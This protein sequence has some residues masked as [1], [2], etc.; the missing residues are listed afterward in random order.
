MLDWYSYTSPARVC[1]LV[2]PIDHCSETNYAR[3][4]NLI[5][6]SADEVRLLDIPAIP[7][8][9]YFNPQTFP[10]GNIM[11]DYVSWMPDKE[12]LFLN[13]FEPFR[14][15]FVV[16][17]VG[18]YRALMSEEEIETI[19]NDLRKLYPSSIVHNLILMDTPFDEIN[20][21]TPKHDHSTK[22]VF[23]HDGTNERITL[24]ETLMCEVSRNFLISFDS[25]ASSYSNITL[26]SPI[27]MT[28]S[29]T[30]TKTISMAKKRL[31]G[32]NSLK[33]PFSSSLAGML[34]TV[35]NKSRSQQGNRGRQAKLFGNFF[36][37]AGK[38]NDALEHFTDATAKLR[39]AE[40]YL[41]LASAL[42]GVGISVILLNY[43]KASYRLSSDIL[44]PA[45]NI[46][47]HKFLSF[48]SSSV[49]KESLSLGRVSTESASNYNEALDRRSESPRNSTN[50]ASN[51]LNNANSLGDLNSFTIPEFIR[52]ISTRVLFYYQLITHDYENIVPDI[53]YVETLLR[54]VKFMTTLYLGG[55]ELNTSV[56]L[57][58]TKSR[59]LHKDF[60]TAKPEAT[61]GFLKR[62][63]LA[64]IGKVFTIQ[65][66]DFNLSDQCNI[67]CALATIYSDLGLQR[68]K[69]S[70]LRVLLVALCLKL[71]PIY[72]RASSLLKKQGNQSD[73][74]VL[75]ANRN[76]IFSIRNIFEHLFY[77]YQINLETE[78]TSSQAG[79][80]SQS[81]WITLQLSVIKLCLRVTETIGD[82]CYLA[83]LYILL[84]TRYCHCLPIHDQCKLKE[85]L[86]E[87]VLS[88]AKDTVGLP[89]WDPFLVRRVKLVNYKGKDELISFRD[90]EKKSE[91]I[92]LDASQNLRRDNTNDNNGV[93]VFNPFE[94]KPQPFNIKD[95]LLVENEVHHLKVKL[96]NP[97][98]FE[99][100]ITDLE[101]MTEK[102]AS[103]ITLKSSIKAL[104]SLPLGVMSPAGMNLFSK[105]NYTTS[106][107]SGIPK[108][109]LSSPLNEGRELSESTHAEVLIRIPPKSTQ[110]VIVPFRPLAIGDLNVKGFQIAILA[111]R[112]QFF[113]IIDR[114]IFV[115][116][117][118]VKRWHL[119]SPRKGMGH[120]V[121][122]LI[123]NLEQ[124]HIDSRV[125]ARTLNLIV[126]PSQP[127][128]SLSSLLIINNSALILE[129]ERM[130]FSVTL[131]NQSN[132]KINYLSFSF[133]DSTIDSLSSRLQPINTRGY[134]L[135][136]TD[137]YELEWLLL[138]CKPFQ[139][140][141][142]EEI[143][144]NCKVINPGDD[145]KIDYEVT[146]KRGMN[147]L[148]IILEYSNK[149]SNDSLKNLVK[150]VEVPVTFAVAPSLEVAGFDV[151]P[152]F[153]SS[154]E[155]FCSDSL[156]NSSYPNLRGIR[157]WILEKKDSINFS[158]YC[159]M[160]LDLR[161]SWKEPLNVNL[162]VS[163]PR[164]D[165]FTVNSE[166]PSW[167]TM[168]F[169]LPKKRVSS[170]D[171][172]WKKQIPSLRQKQYVKDYLM[173][174]EENLIMRKLH[175]LR[176]HVLD[177]VTGTWSTTS[178]SRKPR[179]GDVELRSIRL[180]TRVANMLTVSDISLQH[181]VLKE[182][183]PDIP[184]V[185][186][187]AHVPIA[188]EEF[189]TLKTIIVNN[190]L[191]EVVG[192]LRHLPM[193]LTSVLSA[194][195][196][197]GFP[198]ST[199]MNQ[200]SIGRRILLNGMFQH[201]IAES[202]K[203]GESRE[204]CISFTI[205][206]KGEY[207][208]GSILDVFNSNGLRVVTDDPLYIN[209]L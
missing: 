184:L 178:S 191:Q 134:F 205:L 4:L 128:L 85:N 127:V 101:I 29:Q 73:I 30:L 5:R 40:D 154:I 206:E 22:D 186:S 57:S 64:E 91:S 10:S 32:S 157:E 78:K 195:S 179:S 77:V 130:Q 156:A 146:G 38:V 95:K 185:S 58:I 137:V 149:V 83:K 147:D 120:T 142:K 67:Y 140:I 104:D 119:D 54:S 98:A 12:T 144:K 161:N 3:Y 121:D 44:L 201:H 177:V 37:L 31:L 94:K 153:T 175:W 124:S 72:Q 169:F 99:L 65:L 51:S 108:K 181:M 163:F 93:V 180:S 89:Y 176:L 143:L 61:I 42:E 74:L 14:K 92:N 198:M 49:S 17:G 15:I 79:N 190:S 69:A 136:A 97:Y 16:L 7:E 87:L 123:E 197:E 45:L 165:D 26:R 193:P 107:V 46:H 103:V 194:S 66:A 132:T 164:S 170:N 53:V 183:E 100:D 21:L 102:P 86:K 47:K 109:S 188:V 166:I 182:N 71:E 116:P 202:I 110:Q 23:Y 167:R 158:E 162:N 118:R 125:S 145:I 34:S 80:R 27:S 6:S 111:S 115:A 196:N 9:T 63:I 122:K 41:W 173:S 43:L 105:L 187:E 59:P 168:R 39:A 204:I 114:E 199:M 139:I 19:L 135:S 25:Y 2:V 152:L 207:E 113:R 172:D 106:N 35:D 171:L 56:L 55:N 189:Y 76:E 138:K 36:L 112:P 131:Q 133:W 50:Y 126:I 141:N 200:I 209:A 90:H 52:L 70:I 24:L 20:K 75:E 84:L 208:W 192:I 155:G 150:H 81:N 129:G 8:L 13:D 174:D 28:D 117:D 159:L 18:K 88:G 33:L 96:Q 62:E 68:K 151:L 160:V 203:P 60:R 1:A 48:A 148:K 11:Y 82:K